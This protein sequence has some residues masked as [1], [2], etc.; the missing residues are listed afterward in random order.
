MRFTLALI[1][2]WIVVFNAARLALLALYP[3]QFTD[4]SA[5]EI[6][7]LLT[8]GLIFDLKVMAWLLGPLLLLQYFPIAA[9][10][11]RRTPAL[12]SS[13]LRASLASIAAA[14]LFS[15]IVLLV[16]NLRFYQ[17]SYNHI[18]VDILTLVVEFDL[19]LALARANAI[20]Y[21]AL[22]SIA[23]VVSALSAYLFYRS[24]NSWSYWRACG[25]W[26]V[27]FV[28]VALAARG[29]FD[30][31]PLSPAQAY[32]LGKQ[33][34][35]III[36][37]IM[38]MGQNVIKAGDTNV[39]NS[40][41]AY[42]SDQIDQLSQRWL[43][44]SARQ[45]FKR[46]YNPLLADKINIIVIVIESLSW[47]YLDQLSGSNYQ[48]TPNLDELARQSLIY[49]HFHASGA[50]S[51]DT[52]QP[53]IFGL[54]TFPGLPTLLSGIEQKSLVGLG[55]YASKQGY[56]SILSQ[57][58][59]R[60]S[61]YLDAHAA[62]A[63]FDYYYGQQDAQPQL[64]YL[65]STSPYGG[66]DYEHLQL[67]C[68]QISSLHQAGS[69]VLSLAFTG[70]TH[71]PWQPTLQSFAIHPDDND[72]GKFLNALAYTDW[73]VGQ[74]IACARNAGWHSDSVFIITSDHPRKHG[75]TRIPL[76]IHAPG[77]SDQLQLQ[78]RQQPTD[79][80]SLFASVVHLLG[81]QQSFNSFGAS[82]FTT[83]TN[84]NDYQLW[85]RQAPLV[86]VQ[87]KN[88][89]LQLSE[90]GNIAYTDLPSSTSNSIQTHYLALRWLVSS[91]SF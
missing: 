85:R 82:I 69:P 64:D 81:Y 68:Q 43:G 17:E 74:L 18:G 77:R 14:L 48:V 54:P 40:R 7:A 27:L 56:Q 20:G 10:I 72:E 87:T 37:P 25:L 75:D 78:L 24:R 50:R 5:I 22:A 3:Q 29:G 58:F 39:A 42:S 86:S 65:E 79:N 6:L 23:I 76:L 1:I 67:V 15:C 89:S 84:S 31:R 60:N 49:Q 35:D 44:I 19:I 62:R 52:V 88:G 16:A 70:R 83:P 46:Q 55:S 9:T 13:L 66:Y 12:A 47:H 57:S 59:P 28:A 63:G 32:T 11:Q 8:R 26:L 73:A 45:L 71:A 38:S 21:L 33:R 36:N 53:L 61:F 30:I 2:L 80:L 41:L 51:I 34:G 4:I 91:N 90:D